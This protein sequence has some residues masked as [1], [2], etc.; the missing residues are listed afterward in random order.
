[1]GVLRLWLG[2]ELRRLRIDRGLTLAQLGRL[3]GYSWQHL[4]AIERGSAVPSEV[5]VAECDAAVLANGRLLSMLPA[6]I[7]EQARV[8][9]QQRRPGARTGRSIW[10]GPGLARCVTRMTW[11][12]NGSP[13]RL[14]SPHG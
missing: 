6:V 4:G 8:R 3:V 11:I 9:H 5:V 12:G 2:A 10:S 13:M 1:M 7:R 14:A